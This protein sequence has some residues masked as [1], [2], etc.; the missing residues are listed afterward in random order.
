MI[1]CP[2]DP[3]YVPIYLN[4]V[5]FISGAK[6][7]IITAFYGIRWAH[8]V[9]GFNSPTGNPF[10]QLVFEG[11]QR[12]CQIETTKKEPVTSGMIKT[13]VTKYGGENSTIPDLR[14]LLTC[15]LGFAGFLRIDELL[16][17]KL[18]HIKIQENLLEIVIPKLKKDQHRERNVVYISRIKSE[19]CP[20]KYLE[21][22]LRKAKLDVSNDKESPFIWRIF[23]TKSSHKISK[24]KG[25]SY[26][27]FKEIFESYISE[28]TTTPSYCQS[29]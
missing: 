24:T 21:A 27:R 10:V 14:F 4:H 12:L 26:S 18:E 9:I 1:S 25:I 28:I 6:G 8:H 19:C 22:Y 29:I 2:G 13:L 17:L 11:C 20:V 23:K 15:F 3:F 16:D 5:P 7:S